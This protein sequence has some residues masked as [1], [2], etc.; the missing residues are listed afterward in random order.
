MSTIV[1]DSSCCTGCS[2]KHNCDANKDDESYVN[3]DGLELE[4]QSNNINRNN[5][6]NELE[7]SGRSDPESGIISRNDDAKEK[8]QDRN[9]VYYVQW[10]WEFCW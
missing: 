7:L 4:H 5:D 1:R 10:G 2:W 6:Q 3:E 8:D 9:D